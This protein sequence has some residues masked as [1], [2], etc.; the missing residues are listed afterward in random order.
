MDQ[1][2]VLVLNAGRRVAGVLRGYDPFMNV[3]LDDAVEL[4]AGDDER[5]LGLAMI[6]G[7][8]IVSLE[9]SR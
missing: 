8:S 6:R 2:M 4:V 5:P 7:N 1:R 9:S 3:V